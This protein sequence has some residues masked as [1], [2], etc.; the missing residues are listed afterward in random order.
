MRVF[1]G[2]IVFEGAV[3][4]EVVGSDVENHGDP[5]VKL[6]MVSS[7]K[8]ETSSTVQRVRRCSSIDQLDDRQA[9]VAADQRGLAGVAKILPHS[10]VVVVL[11]FEPVIA[12]PCPGESGRPVPARR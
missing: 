2:G 10:V 4:V 1:G 12:T 11:P 9:D 5:G 3:A 6:S 7:W 8:L